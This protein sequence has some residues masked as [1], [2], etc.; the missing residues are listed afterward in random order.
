MRADEIVGGVFARP[1]VGDGLVRQVGRAVPFIAHGLDQKRPGVVG[2]AYIAVDRL[3]GEE[4]L[5]RPDIE[6]VIVREIEQTHEPAGRRRGGVGIVDRGLDNL[7]DDGLQVV[8]ISGQQG[9]V[10]A[11]SGDVLG[12]RTVEYLC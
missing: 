11:C 4:R 5:E 2:L 7:V 6:S 3:G 1:V 12:D 10:D 9:V 8:F